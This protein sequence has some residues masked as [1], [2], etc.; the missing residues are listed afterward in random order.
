MRTHVRARRTVIAL[1][2]GLAA[3]LEGH[4]AT[5]PISGTLDVVVVDQGGAVYSG[6]AIGT[7]FSG[8]ISDVTFGGQITN[9]STATSFGCRIAAG[10]LEVFNDEA[11]DAASAAVLNQLTGSS[12][13]AAGQVYDSVN[14]E[15]DATTAGGGR[16]EVGV[17][18]LLDASAFSDSL[19]SN[20]PFDPAAVRV[21]LF[22]VFEENSSG[23]AIFDGIGRLRPLPEPSFAGWVVG[24]ALLWVGIRA[25]R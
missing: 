9:G 8:S 6:S 18:Y 3:A 22:F 1:L 16:I 25:R 2:V 12:L 7:P 19:P 24:C 4:A 21:A 14:L 15:G 5:I 10:G 20:Y 11:I 17:S 23:Q 13:F